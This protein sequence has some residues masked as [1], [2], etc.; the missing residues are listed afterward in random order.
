MDKKIIKIRIQLILASL[1]LLKNLGSGLAQL[2]IKIWW[3]LSLILVFITK[4][5]I[6]PLM[7]FYL[8][9]KKTIQRYL[10][11]LHYEGGFLSFLTRQ[12]LLSIFLFLILVFIFFEGRTSLQGDLFAE[13]MTAPDDLDQTEVDFTMAAADEA[14][15]LKPVCF[16][17]YDFIPTRTETEKYI[18]QAGDT[19][20]SIARKFGVTINTILWENSLSSYSVIRPGQSL[21]IL[22]VTGLSYKIKSGDTVAKIAK[23]YKSNE[24]AITRFNNLE[25]TKLVAGQIVIIPDGIKPAPPPAPAIFRRTTP[26]EKTWLAEGGGTTRTGAGCRNFVAGQCTYYVAQKYCITFSGHAKSWL[27]NAS[28]AGY[29]IGKTPQVGAI[30]S[31]RESY[32]GHV[33]IVEEVRESTLIISEMNHLGL[34]KVDKREISKNSRLIN[35]YIYP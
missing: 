21:K 25:G 33:A 23:T 34:W 22:P 13:A 1:K 27:A 19:I 2:F 6:I 11:N 35:G 31:L 15:T 28:R 32:Y 10:A 9:V 18:V 24:E 26:Q 8:K 29:A 14:V 12:R 20:S 16:F 30:I 4:I 5:V 3:L 17:D 7:P